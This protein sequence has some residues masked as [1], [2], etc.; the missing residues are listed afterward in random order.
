M[1]L[2]CRIHLQLPNLITGQHTW[3]HAQCPVPVPSVM[4]PLPQVLNPI[5]QKPVSYKLIPHASPPL[6]A[7]EDSLIAKKGFFATKNLW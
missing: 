4:H 1:F 7:H 6:M 2:L 3:S 5:T